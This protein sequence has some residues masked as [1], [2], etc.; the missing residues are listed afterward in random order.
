MVP[1]LGR[2]WGC[3]VRSPKGPWPPWP[4]W[5][6]L[7][8]QH[9][10]LRRVDHQVCFTSNIWITKSW[11]IVFPALSTLS[12]LI[13]VT[14]FLFKRYWISHKILLLQPGLWLSKSLPCLLLHPGLKP[15]LITSK[16]WSCICY[17][18]RRLLVCVFKPGLWENGLACLV[19]LTCFWK[20]VW[21][22]S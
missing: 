2:W 6:S 5:S 18:N 21:H 10:P 8:G 16:Q 7:A 13:Q 15:F 22:D 12:S 9:H 1:D 19:I 17:I 4:S 14:G 20:K 3:V 11:S